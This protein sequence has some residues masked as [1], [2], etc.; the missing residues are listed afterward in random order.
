MEPAVSPSVS[1]LL[2]EAP[3]ALA[4]AGCDTPRLDAEVLLAH[5]LGRDRAWLYAHPQAMLSPDQLH[6]YRDLISRRARR[7]PV[8]YLTGHKEFFGLDFI[9][10][11]EVL[12]PRP[13]T[14]LLIEQALRWAAA[15][16]PLTIADV[17]TGSGVI[18]V[19]LA[20]HLSQARLVATDTSPAA[21]L[22]ARRNAVRH[23]VADRVHCVQGDLLTPLAGPFHLIVANPPYL[24]HAE[25]SAAPPEVARWEPRPALDGGP[26]GLATIR[27]LLAMAPPRLR[28]NGA[29]LVEIGA[30][31]RWEV[32]ALAR[33]H[34]PQA[35][36]EILRDYAR[37]DRLLV[38][39]L[40]AKAPPL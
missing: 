1:H 19:T 11:P 39:R 33:R 6:H 37:R 26:D 5:V 31:Q 14:E 21:L 27:R 25:L 30:G 18:A 3:R 29:L 10:T 15:D 7:E 36:V 13:E 9:V 22:V 8:A 28:S 23:R 2:Q 32:L 4:A 12:I 35:T 34:F 16:A 17:G 24:T 20:V 38:V 40:F